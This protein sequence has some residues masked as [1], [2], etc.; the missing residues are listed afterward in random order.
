MEAPGRIQPGTKMPSLFGKEAVSAFAEFPPEHRE[1]V[2]AQLHDPTLLDD[3][4]DQIKI[5]SDFMYHT[6]ANKQSKIQPGGVL[7]DTH[8]EN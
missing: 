6:G 1:R 8:K 2:R 5:M 7:P 4:A 3:G